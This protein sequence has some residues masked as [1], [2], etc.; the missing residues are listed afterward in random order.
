LAK[1]RQL[2][3]E[4]MQFLSGRDAKIVSLQIKKAEA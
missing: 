1:R 2:M 3:E 4:W